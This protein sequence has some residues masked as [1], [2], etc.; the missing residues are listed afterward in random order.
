MTYVTREGD[1]ADR[2][3]WAELGSEAA[4]VPLL[5]ANPHLAELPPLLPYGIELA[6]PPAVLPPVDAPIRLWGGR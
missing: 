4:L 3:A 6:L 5:E 2:I 1:T